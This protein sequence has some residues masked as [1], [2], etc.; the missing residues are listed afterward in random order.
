MLSFQSVHTADVFSRSLPWGSL[1]LNEDPETCLGY[2]LSD[3][4]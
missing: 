4:Y 1:S 3:H 2:V